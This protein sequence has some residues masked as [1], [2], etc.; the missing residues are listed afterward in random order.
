MAS[1]GLSRPLYCWTPKPFDPPWEDI[2]YS[3]FRRRV[4]WFEAKEAEIRI[5][6][7]LETFSE[8]Q[9]F[10]NQKS[11]Y[12]DY[13]Y[14]PLNLAGFQC[15]PKAQKS[16][17]S[18]VATQLWEPTPGLGKTGLN[19]QTHKREGGKYSVWRSPKFVTLTYLWTEKFRV[20]AFDPDCLEIHRRFCR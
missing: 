7:F 17:F 12:L 1:K 11:Q 3:R 10:R 16:L 20:S 5:L 4:F 9:T 13:R 18:S 14:F 15:S 8:K 19:T 6:F 2:L